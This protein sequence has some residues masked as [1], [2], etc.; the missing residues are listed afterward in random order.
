M[1]IFENIFPILHWCW[2]GDTLSVVTWVVLVISH[3]V[4]LWLFSVGIILFMKFWQIRWIICCS[5]ED[6]LS[7]SENEN[8]VLRQKALNL[9]P[10]RNR[11]GFVK[12]FSDVSMSLL[13]LVCIHQCSMHLNIYNIVNHVLVYMRPYEPIFALVNWNLRLCG[14]PNLIFQF[15][16]KLRV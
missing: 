14:S 3:P 5:M 4:K 11:P 6:K 2:S 13:V 7:N 16:M 9:S 15:L 12:S 10:K 1:T 8:R